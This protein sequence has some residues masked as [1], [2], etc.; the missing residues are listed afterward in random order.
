MTR[1]KKKTSTT[2]ASKTPAKKK[3]APPQQPRRRKSVHGVTRATAL[4]SAKRFGTPTE[5]MQARLKFELDRGDVTPLRADEKLLNLREAAARLGI[6]HQT[7]RQWAL[8]DKVVYRRI[9]GILLMIPE[10]EVERLRSVGN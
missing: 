5:R 1:D 3:T 2:R 10:S 8:R 9:G 7:L 4:R 6:A